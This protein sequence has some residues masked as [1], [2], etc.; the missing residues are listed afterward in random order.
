MTR[1]AQAG[2]I[3]P[4]TRFRRGLFILIIAL[5]GDSTTLWAQTRPMT[6]GSDPDRPIA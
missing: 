6:A 3:G 1:Q 4:S 5:L 2:R